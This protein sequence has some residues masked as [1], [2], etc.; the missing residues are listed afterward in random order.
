MSI[1]QLERNRNNVNGDGVSTHG[2]LANAFPIRGLG[3]DAI[4]VA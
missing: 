1:L 4:F 2:N 3:V